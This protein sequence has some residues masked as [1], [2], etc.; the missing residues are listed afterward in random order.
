MNPDDI[1]WMEDARCRDRDD[2][3]WPP[4][5]KYERPSAAMVE[6]LAEAMDFCRGCPV[7]FA[8]RAYA[9]SFRDHRGRV[10]LQG[11]W[12]GRYY[13]YAGRNVQ[14]AYERRTARR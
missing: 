11:V 3:P 5:G 13:G 14:R 4:G 9:E 12:G 7:I 8:C 6:R 2:W 10:H 1:A